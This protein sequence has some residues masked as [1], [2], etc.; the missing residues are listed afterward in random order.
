MNSDF[1]LAYLI[2]ACLTM[3]FVADLCGQTDIRKQLQT[4]FI[5][6]EDGDTIRIPEGNY[7]SSGT[8]SMDGKKRI[9]IKGD[10]MNKTI[11][12]FKGQSEGA[13]GI[14]IT[15]SSDISIVG[16][17]VEDAKGDGIKVKDTD[18]IAFREHIICVID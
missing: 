10:G 9:V 4:Q 15:H 8:I 11:L 16:L 12:S 17:T 5:M 3:A 18:G 2:T 1:R 14:L 7:T 6:A 13:E